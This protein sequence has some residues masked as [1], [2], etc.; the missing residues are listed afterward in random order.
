MQIT[1][2]Q[3]LKALAARVSHSGN[4][5]VHASKIQEANTEADSL[6]NRS[7]SKAFPAG[8]R[9]EIKNTL[10][11][12]AN[13]LVF[14]RNHFI[15]FV[16]RQLQLISDIRDRRV[17]VPPTVDLEERLDQTLLMVRRELDDSYSHG[18]AFNEVDTDNSNAIV[19]DIVNEAA[20][21]RDS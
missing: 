20:V 17:P 2:R 16:S 6:L 9:E 15:L 8:K 14:G 12:V 13:N 4:N 18:F 1:N 5:V 3:L 7:I 10:L 11:H 19:L 21:S